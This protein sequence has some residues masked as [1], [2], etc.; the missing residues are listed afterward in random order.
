M[1]IAGIDFGSQLAGTT[2]MA[3]SRTD[4]PGIRLFRSERKKPADNSLQHW[5]ADNRPDRIYIDAPLSLPYV[6]RSG[7][8]RDYFYRKADRE[9]KAMSPMFIGGLTARA[10]RLADNWR[11]LG[12]DCFES[13]PGAAVHKLGDPGEFEYKKG[14]SPAAAALE[15]LTALFPEADLPEIPD[16]H[17]FD[18]VLCLWIGLR[19]AAGK[20]DTAGEPE[21]GIILY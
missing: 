10:I 3:V 17:C 21:E 9:L 14:K 18:A 7:S 15:R 11:S 12:I 4:M 6:Y 16:W 8:D 1:Q 20:A 2:V 19:H 5:V 13:Y